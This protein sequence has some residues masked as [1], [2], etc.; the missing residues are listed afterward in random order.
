MIRRGLR[1]S[2][3]GR[4]DWTICGEARDG[5]EAVALAK[6]LDAGL[7]VLD[8]MMPVLHGLDATRLIR[9]ERPGTEVLIFTFVDDPQTEADVLAAGAGGYLLKGEPPEN[10]IA[11]VESLSR[12]VPYSTRSAAPPRNNEVGGVGGLSPRENQVLRLIARGMRTR[13][14]AGSLGITEKTVE[15]HR[16]ALARKLKLDGVA[17][18]VRFAVRNG[19]VDA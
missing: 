18:L 15:S 11:A 7:V 6:E 2:L 17:A 1:H 14:I 4:P 8:L 5:N 13:E 10:L 16:A 19:L 12:H 9:S 3:S